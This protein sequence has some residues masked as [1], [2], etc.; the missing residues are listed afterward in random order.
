M[1]ITR[2]I[3]ALHTAKRTFRMFIA[4][5]FWQ[6]D[7]IQPSPPRAANACSWPFLR[8]K[9]YNRKSMPQLITPTYAFVFPL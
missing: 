8:W 5:A 1:V 6:T 9:R 7:I 3:V 4:E 2:Q